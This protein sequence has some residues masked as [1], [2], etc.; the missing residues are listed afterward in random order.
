ME[1]IAHRAKWVIITPE[2]I[3]ENG[4]VTVIGGRV[5]ESGKNNTPEGIQV[6]DHGEGVLMPALVNAH[7]HLDLTPLGGRPASGNGFI[8]WVSE[9]IE[10]K[11]RL[12]ET[13]IQ[14]GIMSGKKLLRDSGCILAGDHRSFAVMETAKSDEPILQVFREYLGSGLRQFVSGDL[15]GKCSLAAHAPHTTSPELIRHLKTWCRKNNRVFSM[16]VAES[17]EEEEFIT[18]GKGA[19]ATFLKDHGIA[20]EDWELPAESPV[21]HLERL[22]VLDRQTLAVHLV[23]ADGQDLTLLAEKGVKV[24][25]CPRSNMTLTGNL[26]KVKIMQKLGMRPAVGTD[27]L[28]SVSSLDLFDEMRFLA[29]KFP[30]LAPRDILA[31]GTRNGAVALGMEKELGTLVPGKRAAILFIPVDGKDSASLLD[32][33]VSGQ[34]KTMPEWVE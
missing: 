2:Q 16:H 9:I 15:A 17:T 21:R 8:S 22:A 10:Q 3:F 24:C 20:F 11:S 6:K 31:M 1:S 25:V 23:H 18:T 26:P 29:Q 34:R 28:A 14:D 33:L 4:H 19:W 32:A 7:T 12:T 30:D 27:S 13:E 5:L